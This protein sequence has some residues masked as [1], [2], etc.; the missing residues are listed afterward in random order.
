MAD[1]ADIDHFYGGDVAVTVT[2]DLAV[3]TK[4]K[5]TR[6]RVIRRL[7][8]SKTDQRGSAYPWQPKYGVGLP[9][10]IGDPLEIRAVQGDVASQMKREDS[11]QRVPAPRVD[12]EPLDIGAS[13]SVSYT[14]LSGLPKSFNF[15]LEP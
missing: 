6:Q 13:I 2:G 4:D 11:V 7:L 15:D 8:T 12:V 3:A 10:R 1:L 9:E 14:D 5:R